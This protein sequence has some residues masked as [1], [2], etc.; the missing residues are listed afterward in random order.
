M[1]SFEWYNFSKT[2]ASRSVHTKQKQFSVKNKD[3]KW[4][5]PPNH[6]YSVDLTCK[7]DHKH[8]T[9]C[10]KKMV[11]FEFGHRPEAVVRGVLC[12]L[13]CLETAADTKQNIAHTQQ[14]VQGTT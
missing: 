4:K 12:S 5:Q 9:N 13:P 7:E 14:S 3:E 2:S 6:A 10:V 1:A 8:P 11:S